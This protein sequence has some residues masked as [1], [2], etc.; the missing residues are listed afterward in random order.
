MEN[1]FKREQFFKENSK[2]SI[3]NESIELENIN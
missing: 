1:K 2:N 3:L